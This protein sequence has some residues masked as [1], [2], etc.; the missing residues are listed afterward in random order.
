M[1]KL[2]LTKF[3]EFKL[4]LSIAFMSLCS[5]GLSAQQ[6][7][8]T[9]KDEKGEPLSGAAV[10]VKGTSNGTITDN[11]GAFKLT[12]VAKSSILVVTFVGYTT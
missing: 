1:K 4:L 5:I 6:I 12:N 7:S 11:N 2:L 3:K 10:L 8:G 9:I